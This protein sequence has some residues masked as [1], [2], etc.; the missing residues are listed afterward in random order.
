MELAKAFCHQ[1]S[2]RSTAL[3]DELMSEDNK[4]I[5]MLYTK[6]ADRI[7]EHKGYCAEHP[8]KRND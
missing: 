2:E 4:I 8:L 1:A 6:V 3:L 5:D 7:F